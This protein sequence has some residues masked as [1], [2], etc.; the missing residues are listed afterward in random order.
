[1][2]VIVLLAG[3]AMAQWTDGQDATYVVGQADFTS[4]GA[5]TTQNGLDT[6]ND[7]AVDTVNN[8]LYVAD[9]SNNRVLRYA[10]PITGNQ[11]N[12][13]AVLGQADFTSGEANRGGSVA[14]NTLNAPRRVAVD[15]SGRLW[16]ADSLNRRVL[17]FDSAHTK[18][19]GANA[20]GV[21][22]KANFTTSSSATTQSGMAFVAGLGLA[23][24]GT[25]WVADL[26]NNRVLRFDNAAAKTDGA[27]ADGVLGQTDFTS[28]ASA[29]T[30]A[31]MEGPSDTCVDGTTLY[32]ADHL[33]NRVL[34]FD[35]AAAKANG[36]NADGVL[37]QPD[38]TSNGTAVTQSG[39]DGPYGVDVDA[40]G[41][42]YVADYYN[43]RVLIFDSASGK[44]NGA[45]ADNVLGQ[46]SFTTTI[47][48]LD[49]DGLNRVAGVGVDS[50]NDR[51][52]VA[53]SDHSRVLEMDASSA[54]PVEVTAFSVD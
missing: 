42:L 27:N 36:A 31:G 45:N 46:E 29:T 33:N 8:K 3:P 20:D 19:N 47:I 5:A 18:A 21:L 26:G 1:L 53:D 11:P 49:Q 37:G 4:S 23:A 54:L 38:F 41:R 44:A 34:R 14:A 7:V 50:V 22:G 13:E 51:L 2:A 12:A 28:S 24:D 25:L 40:A 30:Q 6:S 15:A 32:V 39:M 52:F 9:T 17:R 43:Y 48:V 35:N 10:Y 16:V